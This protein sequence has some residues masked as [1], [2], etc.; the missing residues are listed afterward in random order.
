MNIRPGGRLRLPLT[1]TKMIKKT[2][3]KKIKWFVKEIRICW[4]GGGIKW[5]RLSSAFAFLRTVERSCFGTGI[6]G[7]SLRFPETRNAVIS[8][9]EHADAWTSRRTVEKGT[10][11]A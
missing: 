8:W 2:K 5:L 3:I 11:L 7:G 9:R 1:I 6:N 10:S 4:E